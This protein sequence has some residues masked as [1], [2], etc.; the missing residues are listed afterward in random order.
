MPEMRL[1]DPIF[2]TYSA[3]GP[4]TKKKKKRV[5]RFLETGDRRYIYRNELDIA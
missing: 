4:F 1:K 3:C 2:G 5:Q